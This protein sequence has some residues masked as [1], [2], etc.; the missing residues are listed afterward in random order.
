MGKPRKKVSAGNSAR[1]LAVDGLVFWL[2]L[3]ILV[4]VPLAFM[5]R[6]VRKKRADKV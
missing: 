1:G 4:A 3:A 5:D 6:A 2:A